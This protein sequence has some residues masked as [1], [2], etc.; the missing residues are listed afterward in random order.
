MSRMFRVALLLAA[1]IVAG[2]ANAAMVLAALGGLNE[3]GRR[4]A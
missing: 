2:R 1:V 3:I 4:G